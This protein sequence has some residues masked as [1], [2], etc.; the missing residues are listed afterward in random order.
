MK[1]GVRARPRILYVDV[2]RVLLHLGT[3][4]TQRAGEARERAQR[5]GQLCECVRPRRENVCLYLRFVSARRSNGV[6]SSPI[7]EPENA[8]GGREHNGSVDVCLREPRSDNELSGTSGLNKGG[9]ICAMEKADRCEES[10]PCVGCLLC[11]LLGSEQ[12]APTTQA[13]RTVMDSHL[14]FVPTSHQRIQGFYR[15]FGENSDI[16]CL[17]KGERTL[18]KP[19]L[20]DSIERCSPTLLLGAHDPHGSFGAT[21]RVGQGTSRRQWSCC[22]VCREYVK[23]GA[24][25]KSVLALCRSGY[26]PATAPTS[27]IALPL[28]TGK[29]RKFGVTFASG[30]SQARCGFR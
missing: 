9:F 24:S 11:Q 19:T 2:I 17:P 7:L 23:V 1:R 13:S 18:N 27:P 3:C 26:S 22:D 20:G 16:R 12:G 21:D 15:L 4:G 30:A 28:A 5:Q 25:L 8:K 6:V 10:A 14:H 29:S